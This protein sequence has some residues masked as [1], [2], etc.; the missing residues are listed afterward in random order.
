MGQELECKMT[1]QGRR[2]A[3]RAYL[4][5]DH[6]L[7][8]GAN[9]LKLWLK[10]LKKVQADAG[11]LTLEHPDGRAVFDL[12]PAASKWAEKILHPPSRL[13]KLGLKPEHKLKLIGR[14][15]KEFLAE[16]KAF[17]TTRGK[18]DYILLAAESA[19]DLECLEKPGL[20]AMLWIVYPK[21]RND[22]TEMD[23]LHAGR[24][25]GLKDIK[26]MSFSATHTALKF[27]RP[28]AG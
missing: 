16:V 14:F 4:E 18:A 23:V 3:G 25:A 20:G 8:R 1:W 27:V 15:D 28:K 26:V 17:T 19:K 5:T 12:G 10:D 9:R 2:D 11:K 6:I 21:G 13:T 7:F 22:V 24:A